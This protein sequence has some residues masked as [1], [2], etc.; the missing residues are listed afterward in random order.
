MSPGGTDDASVGCP[1]SLTCLWFW[2]GRVGGGAPG[3]LQAMASQRTSDQAFITLLPPKQG[4]GWLAGCMMT[5]TTTTHLCAG[6]LL[7]PPRGGGPGLLGGNSGWRGVGLG[8]RASGSVGGGL[9]GQAFEDS[10]LGLQ[11]LQPYMQHG[12]D[13]SKSAGESDGAMHASMH[14]HSRLA[15]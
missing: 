9:G 13:H 11:H 14:Q 3:L 8:R 2:A 10:Q 12:R 6:G 5:T 15:S 7:L 4:S 1:A